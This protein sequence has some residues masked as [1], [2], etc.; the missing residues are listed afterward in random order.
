MDKKDIPHF[1][2][3]IAY[4]IEQIARYLEINSKDFFEKFANDMTPE[5]FKTIDVILTNPDICQRD[6]AK[7]ILRDRIRTG[8]ILNS[9]EEKGLIKRYSHTK[10]N[11][12]VK[13]MEVTKKGQKRFDE[14]TDIMQPYMATLREKFTTEQFIELRKL[15][16][17][18][19][20]ALSD[21]VK[22]QV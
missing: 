22:V 11:R 8:R 14:I 18:L 13:K 15:L 4:S 19:R 2:D 6:L 20:E 5:E 1:T 7:L 16:A 12:L 10:N 21:M 3:S 17:S 9:L